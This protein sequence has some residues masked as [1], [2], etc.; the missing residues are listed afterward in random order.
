MPASQDS[1]YWSLV[2]AAAGFKS[3]PAMDELGKFVVARKSQPIARDLLYGLAKSSSP[4]VVKPFRPLL[5]DAPEEVRLLVAKKISKVRSHDAV[6]AL[7]ELL[8]GEEKDRREKLSP[9]GWI[10]VEGLTAIT[11][12]NFGPELH[13][14]GRLVEENDKNPSRP[15]PRTREAARP[16][17][18]WISSKW[19]PTGSGARRSSASK[20]RRSSRWWCSTVSSR[21][22]T[23]GTTT[24]TG[25]RV[26]S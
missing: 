23:N 6:D 22:S 9:L 13:Q 20:K 2:G 11:K 21:R 5:F 10:A 4:Y 3:R 12:Q 25:C 24:T 19:G 16:A 26:C 15:A 7:L 18:P 8:K 14:L 1:F 17:R